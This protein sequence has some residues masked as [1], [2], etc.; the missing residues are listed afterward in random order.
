MKLLLDVGADPKLTQKSGNN[1]L[2]LAAGAVS[3]GGDETQQISEEQALAALIA[4]T[5]RILDI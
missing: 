2:M 3:S 4:W 1:A 5:S